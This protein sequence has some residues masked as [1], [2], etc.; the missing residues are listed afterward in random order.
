MGVNDVGP[1]AP[2]LSDE[3]GQGS[4]II[5]RANGSPQA[6]DPCRFDVRCLSFKVVSL[7]G[8]AP[9]RIEPLL[10]GIRREMSHQAGDLD[11]RA[12]HVHPCDD[13][14]DSQAA[15]TLSLPA[16]PWQTQGMCGIAGWAGP[17][18]PDHLNAML[19]SLAHRGPDESGYWQDPSAALGI[20]RLSIID[21]AGGHQPVFSADK[22]VVAVCNGEIYN[23]RELAAELIKQG[24]ILRSGSDVEVIPHLYRRYGLKFV[25]HLRGMFAIALW[26]ARENRLVLARDRVGKKPLV[27]ARDGERLLF[28]SEARALLAT[29]WSAEPDLT[30]LDHVLAF[31]YLPVDSGAWLGLESLPPGHLAVWQDGRLRLERYWSWEPREPLPSAGLGERVEEALEEAVRIRLVSERPLGAF[32]SGGIDSTIVTALMARHHS[33]P[34]KTFSIGFEDPAYDESGF[35]RGVAEYLGTD[36]T[37][38]IVRPDPVATLDLLA[39]AYDQPFADSSAIPTLLLSELT[40]KEVVVALSGDGGDEGFG[41]YER[42]LAAPMLQRLNWLWRAGSVASGPIAGLAGRTGQRKVSRLAREI[43]PQPDLEARYRGLMEYQPESLRRNVWT[44]AALA[45]ARTQLAAEAFDET[46]ISLPE[47]SP[48]GRMRAMDVATY[49]PGDLLVKV[50][51]ASMARSLEVRSPFLDQEVLALA[52]RI[53]DDLLVRGRTTKWI[54]RQL[55]YRLVPRELVDRPKRGFGIPRAAWLRGPLREA[56][57]DLLLDDTARQRGW[58]VP[59]VVEGLLDQHDAGHDQDLYVWPLLMIEVWARRWLD[60]YP[61]KASS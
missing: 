38:L 28:A 46:W 21:V 40:A 15:H 7:V 17:G 56:S 29:G 3:G 35:A 44:P 54:L 48:L 42:Y 19:A 22:S 37:E 49:L 4:S 31:A 27:Y 2:H 34:V 61:A 43:R 20:A 9:A 57:R 51:I 55:A 33:G 58:F 41:G 6:R 60:P 36:H 26:D 8:I 13:A 18:T 52:A 47:M 1:E 45:M 11:S 39:E 59:S 24:V 16:R 25:H 10:E 14:H 30:A 32:L 23:Y 12:T 53:P 5:T 50:D